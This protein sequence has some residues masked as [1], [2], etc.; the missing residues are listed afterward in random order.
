MVLKM[1]LEESIIKCIEEFRECKSLINSDD[2]VCILEDIL[3]LYEYE[4]E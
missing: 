1:T 4:T 2:V 3:S